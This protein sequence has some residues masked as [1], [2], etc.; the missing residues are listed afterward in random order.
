LLAPAQS[1]DASSSLSSTRFR[2]W[3][4]R[5]FLILT[6]GLVVTFSIIA[7]LNWR[8]GLLLVIL[9]ASVQDPLRKLVPGTPGFMALMTAPVFLCAVLGSMATV[10]AWWMD[11][12]KSCPKVSMPLTLLMI[13][14]T[15]AAMISATYGEGSWML[16]VLGALS[17]SII[18]LA[19]I[20]GFH[21]ARRGIDVRLLLS[22][23]CLVHGV[24]LTGSYLEYFGLFDH[25][26]I[27]SDDAFGHQWVRYQ[28]GYIVT[29]IAGFYR[30]GDVMGWHAAAVACLST[31][32]AVSTADRKRWFW[33]A[34]SI[35][36]V[37]AL[38]MC[39]RRKMVFMLPVFLFAL[40]WMQVQVRKPGRLLSLAMFLSVPVI[41]LASISDQLSDD[42]TAIRYYK[43]TASQSFDSL[44]T[45]GFSTVIGTIKQAGFLGSGLGTATPGSHHLKVER[46]RTW[47]ESGTSRVVV[48]LGVPGAI[49][50]MLVMLGIVVSCW[51]VV[52]KSLAERSPLAPYASSLLAFFV[53]NVAS[54][55]VSGQ[56]LADPFIA[57]WL[58]VL[59]GLVLGMSRLP[60]DM[61]SSRL[62]KPSRPDSTRDSWVGTSSV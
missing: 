15:P 32:L 34:L 18:F 57:C 14:S 20:F 4:D 7:F 60:V 21:F 29:F 61:Y 37:G 22:A 17:Y 51:R 53:A 24:M 42:L 41:A 5:V 26:V 23:Y 50:L 48:E 2:N 58:G 59:V 28:Q 46:P 38:L 45:H 49:G 16:T 36:A 19:V 40:G 39:G 33:L 43:D 52:R 12:A 62:A 35:M 3:T 8:V 55:T 10:R 56:I 54:L 25:W 31:A 9:L 6:I 11:F 1:V 13:L 47:Q 27:L 44:H 30:S